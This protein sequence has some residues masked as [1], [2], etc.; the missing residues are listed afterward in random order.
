MHNV[1]EQYAAAIRQRGELEA[2]FNRLS[3]LINEADNKAG[4]AAAH[5]TDLERRRVASGYDGAAWEA[6]HAE[7]YDRFRREVSSN[8]SLR[9]RSK[10]EAVKV[11]QSLLQLKYS[12]RNLEQMAKDPGFT[13]TQVSIGPPS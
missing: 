2:E 8:N 9:D 3:G 12:L 6:S 4:L 1:Q 5:L 11:Q 7:E 10:L 13:I